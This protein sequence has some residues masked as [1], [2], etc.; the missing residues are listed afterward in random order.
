[1]LV[2]E[3]S[4]QSSVFN[5]IHPSNTTSITVSLTSLRIFEQHQRSNIGTNIST[6]SSGGTTQQQQS[7]FL[8]SGTTQESPFSSVG[9]AQQSPFLSG[10]T[11]QQQQQQQQQQ[12]PFSSGGTTQQQQSPFSS[13]LSKDP[14]VLKN[15]LVALY[16]VV[17]PSKLQK[18]DAV[19]Q[20][21]RTNEKVYVERICKKY[22]ADMRVR[23]EI[24]KID[25][26]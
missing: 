11:T 16:Q 22:G 21:Y 15:A 8:S 9:T 26:S 12:S 10:G 25:S 14:S 1:M 7:P 6:L 19:L 3:F 17:D 23:R 4:S 5:L 2:F 13:T 20:R 24:H 18:L